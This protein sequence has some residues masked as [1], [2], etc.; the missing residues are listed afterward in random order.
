LRAK[1]R[2]IAQASELDPKQALLGSLPEA[3]K[4]Y[5]PLH[6]RVLVATYVRPER[7]KGG[8]I[9]ADRSLEEDRFQGK[10]GLVISVGPTAFVDD[11]GVK[12]GGAKVLP[13]DWVT[14]RPADGVEIFFVD[15]NGREATPCRLFEDVCILGRTPD[16]ALVW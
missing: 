5:E 14:Y 13:G 1:L 6:N 7:T 9:L 2:E 15:E 16:P 10:V 11:G 3:V 8:I 4:Q 12:F